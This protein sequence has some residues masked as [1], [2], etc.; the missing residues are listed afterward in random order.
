MV[1]TTVSVQ[2]HAADYERLESAARQ[3]GLSPDVLVRAYVR[4]GLRGGATEDAMEQERRRQAGLDALDR[5]AALR[6]DLRGD[7][8]PSVDAV[9]I[10]REGREELE[11]RPTL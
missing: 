3:L 5:L 11:Q 9:Q 4:A 6:E 7:G 10:V 1:T 2:L 8:Y